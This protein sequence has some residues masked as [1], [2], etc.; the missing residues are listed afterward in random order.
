MSADLL[1][2]AAAHINS[3]AVLAARKMG[4]DWYDYPGQATDIENHID[5]WDPAAARLVARWLEEE[6]RFSEQEDGG[7]P[8]P[9]S[10]ALARRILGEDA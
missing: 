1:R 10:T 4:S 3:V 5:L 8:F 6:A 9:S 2:R 7:G